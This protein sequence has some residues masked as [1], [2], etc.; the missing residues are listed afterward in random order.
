MSLQ[1]IYGRSGSGKTHVFY[2]Q[3]VE[4]S[5]QYPNTNYIAIVPEQFSSESRRGIIETHPLHGFMNIDVLSFKRLAYRLFE[6]QGISTL[7]E[8]DKIGQNFIIRKV[9]EDQKDKLEI[10]SGKISMPG[11]VNEMQ[12]TL[13]ELHQ[14]NITSDNIHQMIKISESRK[15]L[16]RKL[17]DVEIIYNAFDEYT[18]DRYI[19]SE[20]MLEELCNYISKS[21]LIKSSVIYFD[22]FTGFTPIQFKII[23]MLIKTA[24]KVVFTIIIPPEQ[25]GFKDI[26]EYELFALSKK[27]IERI[28]N[29]AQENNI[30]KENDILLDNIIPYRFINNPVLGYVEKNI[31]RQ[32]DK[33]DNSIQAGNILN[34]RKCANLKAEASYVAAEILRLVREEHYRYQDIAV[35]SGNIDGYY[36]HFEQ[37]FMTYGVPAFIDHK[38]SIGMNPFVDV[39]NAVLLVIERNFSYESVFHYLKLGVTDIPQEDIDLMENF[40]IENGI[41]GYKAYSSIWQG[42]TEKISQEEYN[43]LNCIRENFLQ[44]VEKLRNALKNKKAA[45]REYTKAI[46]EFIVSQNIQLKLLKYEEEFAAKGNAALVREYRQ[47]YSVIISVLDKMVSMLGDEIITAKEYRMILEAGFD[48]IKIGTIPVGIDR[49]MLGDIERTRLHDVK[50]LFLVGANE[51][52]IPKQMSGSGI[53]C[54]TDKEYLRENRFVVGT[55][56]REEGFT[57]KLYLYMALTKP[58]QKLYMTFANTNDTGETLRKS[59]IVNTIKNMFSDLKIVDDELIGTD[60]KMSRIVNEQTGLRYIS[61]GIRDYTKGKDTSVLWKELYN[62]MYSDKNYKDRLANMIDAAFY[63]GRKEKLEESLARK[64]YG[65]NQIGITRLERYALCAYKQFLANG[66]HIVPRKEHEINVMDIGNIYHKAIKLFSDEVSSRNIKWHDIDKELRGELVKSSVHKALDEYM[67]TGAD[68]SARSAY[69]LNKIEK[70][71]DK[72]MWVL[73][74]QIKRGYFEP[75]YIEKRGIHGVIDRVDTYKTDDK[76]YVRVVDY[77]S[78]NKKFNLQDICDGLQLQLATYMSDVIKILSEE[79]PDK[80]IIPAGIYYYGIKDEF[81]DKSELNNDMSDDNIS[82]T[83]FPLY[84]MSGITNISDGMQKYIDEEAFNNKTNSDIVDLNYTKSGNYTEKSSVI[85]TD[86]FNCL[87]NY[88]NEKSE[89]MSEE[90]LSG[91]IDINPYKKGTYTACDYCEFSGI[92]SRDLENMRQYRESNITSKDELWTLIKNNSEDK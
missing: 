70:V 7:D 52:V 71:M 26:K 29:L 49:V 30:K 5:I 20:G 35:I 79:I 61:E 1:F 88:V 76:V 34:I 48:G 60:E 86:D 21:E 90:I 42:S 68:D 59:Y 51:G 41:R 45:V 3:I 50:V 23:N 83:Q 84:K 91:N 85:K 27:T 25:I 24:Q 63:N 44:P 64:L 82:R 12:Q 8:L 69:V 87:L 2:N 9:L 15:T 28:N 11:F 92:C 43:R 22:G 67:Q 78:G 36:R 33:T 58:S 89:K 53:I 46:Y 80:E 19:T 75:A 38:H 39:I 47:V 10:Y 17:K 72:T 65:T 40:V 66:L 6:E 77:K 13:T 57:Q 14:Y 18:K 16:Q 56:Q 62:R 74:E 32:Y 31:F 73:C 4:N 55:T 54:D 81:L 37:E